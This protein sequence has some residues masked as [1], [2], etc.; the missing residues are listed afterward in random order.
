MNSNYLRGF[1]LAC[2]FMGLLFCWGTARTEGEKQDAQRSFWYDASSQSTLADAK[3]AVFHAYRGILTQGYLPGS[4]WVKLRVKGR[5][6]HG[7]PQNLVLRIRPTYLDNIA[8]FDP[9]VEL[10]PRVTGD[11]V[12]NPEYL[13]RPTT[14]GFRIPLQ[15]KDRDIYL[16]L[17]STSTHL[18]DIELM[19]EEK[20]LRAE[21]IQAF[22]HGIFF[23]V[24]ALILLW[25]L[26][27][28]I[29]KRDVLL[30]L[31]F[32]KHLVVTLYALGYLGYLPY[33]FPAG[34]GVLNPDIIFSSTV[35]A[36]MVV[37]LKFQIG[38]LNE[39][40]LQG[41][42]LKI[43]KWIFVTPL[44]A[45]VL[46]L[47]GSIQEALKLVALVTAVTSLLLFLVVLLT[48]VNRLKKN[49]RMHFALSELSRESTLSNETVQKLHR[50]S[51]PLSK[52][53]LLAY[54]GA[55][56]LV[57]VA[58]A[59]QTLGLLQGDV[60]VLYAYLFH[61][62][63]SSI[64]IL[65][66]LLFRGRNL[67]RQQNEIARQMARTQGELAAE[68]LAQEDQGRM[69]EMLGHEIKTPLAVLQFAIDEWVND[70][71]ERDKINESIDQIRKVTERSIV[72][73]LQS[74]T[75]VTFEMVDLIPLLLRQVNSTNEPDR[76]RFRGPDAA[77]IYSNALLIEQ[78]LG[79]LI[80]NALKYG[81][82]STVIEVSICL[83]EHA[84]LG[85][86]SEGFEIAIS[87][88]IGLAGSPEPGMVFKKYYRA[89][90]SKKQPGSGLGL[91]LVQAFIRFLNGE[92]DY[93]LR[94]NRVEFLLWLPVKQF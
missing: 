22:W 65:F 36:V 12:L 78:V 92:I 63:I 73:I 20:F 15:E 5:P 31:F 87:N 17:I 24:M 82:A 81:K 49:T 4:T 60:V 29:D 44:L 27:S 79:N 23:G 85:K 89:E 88:Q 51:S 72:A 50:L 71:K 59:T 55:I 39:Y 10:Q 14:L 13:V 76:F 35:F 1:V 56:V 52:S 37:S 66:L 48:P 90:G 86:E 30:G 67:Q 11:N 77:V 16:R 2:V 32:L 25:A 19:A 47:T 62:F 70:A 54:Y 75:E 74:R 9:D 26:V 21:S 68:R 64:L 57:L 83:S 38:V 84:R 58:A 53:V 34:Q 33:A 41:W 8:L 80:D 46:A 93:R 61:S 6:D 91:Y 69:V 18:M 3:Q 42:R 40:G 43:F 7:V 94:D 28:W 45:V